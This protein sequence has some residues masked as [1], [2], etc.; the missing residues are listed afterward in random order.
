MNADPK[1]DLQNHWRWN[2]ATLQDMSVN[3]KAG[4]AM[5]YGD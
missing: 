1:C 2:V 3:L 5:P 4:D